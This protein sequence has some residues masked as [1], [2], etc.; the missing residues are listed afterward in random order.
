M[1]KQSNESSKNRMRI[2]RAEDKMTLEEYDTC[3]L[4]YDFLWGGI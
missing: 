4:D 3:M 2:K 1:K